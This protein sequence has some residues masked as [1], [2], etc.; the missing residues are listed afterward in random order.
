MLSP[1]GLA[2]CLVLPNREKPLGN[3][4]QLCSVQPAAPEPSPAGP[5]KGGW[6]PSQLYTGNAHSPGQ[7]GRHWQGRDMV[8]EGPVPGP[9]LS[10][11]QHVVPVPVTG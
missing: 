10:G 9:G 11:V 7:K 4:G 1:K 2:G 8:A 3:N 6:K 5:A